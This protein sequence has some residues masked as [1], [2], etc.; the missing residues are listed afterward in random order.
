MGFRLIKG[1]FAPSLPR[2]RPDG[3]SVRFKPDNTNLLRGLKGRSIKI[4]TTKSGV[5]SVQLRY[6]GVDTMESLA[7]TPWSSDATKRNLT[8]IGGSGQSKQGDSRG[9]ILTRRGGKN[10]RPISFVFAGQASESDGAD[11]YLDTGRIKASVNF[12]LLREGQG[13]P[14]FYY[15]LFADLREVLAKAARRA[16]KQNKGV[17]ASDR[18]N[19]GV[20]FTGKASLATM[21]PVFPK[22][23]RRLESWAQSGETTLGGFNDWL[24]KGEDAMEIISTAHDGQFEDVVEVSN[25]QVRMTEPPENLKFR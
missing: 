8:L 6:E 1:W 21:P 5:T 9:Y 19:A 13:Y 17:W 23:W 14:M 16:R 24:A 18:T 11:V 15:T 2:T 20:A 25:G 12:Q 4:H 10:N 3:D 7:A 22:L